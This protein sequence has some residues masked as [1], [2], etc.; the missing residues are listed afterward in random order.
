MDQMNIL[1]QFLLKY[2]I[3]VNDQIFFHFVPN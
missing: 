2:Q 3:N 1:F